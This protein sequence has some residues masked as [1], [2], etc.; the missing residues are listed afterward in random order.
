MAKQVRK[1]YFYDEDHFNRWRSGH[2]AKIHEDDIIVFLFNL[3]S[4]SI[5]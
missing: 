5:R 3:A 2:K 1:W 4:P